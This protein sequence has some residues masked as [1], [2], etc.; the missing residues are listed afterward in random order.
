MTAFTLLMVTI[1]LGVAK[2]LGAPIS[3][4][5]VAAPLWVPIAFVVMFLIAVLWFLIIQAIFG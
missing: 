5:I 4:L 2:L 3:W 1:V